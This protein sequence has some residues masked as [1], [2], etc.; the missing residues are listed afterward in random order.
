MSDGPTCVVSKEIDNPIFGPIQIFT[1]ARALQKPAVTAVGRRDQLNSAVEPERRE[2]EGLE[3]NERIVLRCDDQ[4]GDGDLSQDMPGA[5]PLIVVGRVAKSAIFCCV[6]V[7]E[8]PKGSN[9]V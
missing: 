7:I 5:G 3:G 2:V 4:R 9:G 6:A 8:F 1:L